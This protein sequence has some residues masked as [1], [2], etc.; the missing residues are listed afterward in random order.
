MQPMERPEFKVEIIEDNATLMLT[1]Q[2]LHVCRI[3]F[4]PE[5]LRLDGY[6]GVAEWFYKQMDYEI[7]EALLEA[8]I[9]AFKAKFEAKG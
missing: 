2:A 7:R 4:P 6:K 3:G 5:T 1:V 9:E 8:V